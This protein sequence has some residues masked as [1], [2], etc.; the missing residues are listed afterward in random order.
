MKTELSLQFA[1]A[2]I[3]IFNSILPLKIHGLVDSPEK[4]EELIES[5]LRD[6]RDVSFTIFPIY[7]K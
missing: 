3:D 2:E 1:V 4:A 7:S 5:L 6:L